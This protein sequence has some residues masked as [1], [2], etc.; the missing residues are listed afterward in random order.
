[1]ARLRRFAEEAERDAATLNVS[2]FGA[3][4]NAESMDRYR[5]AGVDRA[6]LSLPSKDRDEVLPLL[7]RLSA[8]L[9]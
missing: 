7:D 5:E 2:V 3:P 8:L 4:A 1:M 6:I 9:G